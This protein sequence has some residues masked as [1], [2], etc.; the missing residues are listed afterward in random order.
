MGKPLNR[1]PKDL[2]KC[3]ERLGYQFK[4][5]SL[6]RIAL[7]HSSSRGELG[8][9]NERLEFLGDAILGMI[10]SEHLYR[11]LP[12][13]PEGD[14]TKIKSVVVSQAVLAKVSRRLRIRDY[15]V[16]GKGLS[17]RRAL[18]A[19]LLAN[20][21]EAL[22]SA[23][24]LDGGLEAAREFVIHHLH[25][26][27]KAVRENRH[28]RNFKSLLQQYSQHAFAT[29][30]TYRL[31]HEEGPDHTKTF[32]VTS[33]INEKEYGTGSGKSKKEAEQRAAQATLEMLYHENAETGSAQ[34]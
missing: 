17:N 32:H 11:R 34:E 8:W 24:Y 12:D 14:L 31:V 26:E 27:I 15:V 6:L 28:E 10:V 1:V 4:D 30:P 25:R 20:V 13:H 2:A 21:F 18:P 9:S 19:S 3:Q 7:T 16:L 5:Q 22:I 29:T 33:V 23:V